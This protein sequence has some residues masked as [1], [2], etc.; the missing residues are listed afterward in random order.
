MPGRG[1]GRGEGN[2][3]RQYGTRAGRAYHRPQHGRRRV[4][5]AVTKP[6]DAVEPT[7][8]VRSGCRRRGASLVGGAAERRLPATG[9]RQP[10]RRPQR[11]PGR[12]L[13]DTVWCCRG[14]RRADVRRRQRRPAKPPAR[15]RH[16][17]RHARRGRTPAAQPLLR[18]RTGRLRH[19]LPSPEHAV[20]EGRPSRRRHHD[21][22]PRHAVGPRRRG[23]HDLDRSHFPLGGGAPD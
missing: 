5:A 20:P 3:R 2:R 12:G 9:H 23:V 16:F 17:P 21:R 18:P 1:D 6:G 8:R 19:C 7:L 11:T 14:A 4:S 10:H 15:Q 13:A 22:R